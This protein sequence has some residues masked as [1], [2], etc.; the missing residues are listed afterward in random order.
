MILA[1]RNQGPKTAWAIDGTKLCLGG[2][3]T[4]DLAHYEQEDERTIYICVDREGSLFAC[5]FSCQCTCLA[6]HIAPDLAYVAE[7]TIP[8]RSYKAR[9]KAVYQGNMPVVERDPVP[10]VMDACT[11]TLW[12]LEG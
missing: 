12:A 4:L 1:E 9:Q 2:M 7:I 6:T 5:L 3:L 8:A 11:L 10:F